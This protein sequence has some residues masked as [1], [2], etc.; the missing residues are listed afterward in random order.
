MARRKDESKEDYNL[1]MNEYMKARYHA[2]RNKLVSLLGGCCS[3]CKV[4]ENLEL[5]HFD[6]TSKYKSMAHLSSASEEIW[7]EESMKCQLL[8]A[9]CHLEKSKLEGSFEN[10]YRQIVCACGRICNST[11]EYAG[12]KTRCKN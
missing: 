7:S 1:R 4:T 9:D 8:C 10:K 12:H 6:P 11:K 3:K 5:D 2:R